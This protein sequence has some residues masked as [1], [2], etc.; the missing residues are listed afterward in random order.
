[1]SSAKNNAASADAVEKVLAESGLNPQATSKK[2]TVPAQADGEKSENTDDVQTEDEPTP[3]KSLKSRLTSVT[4]K[5]KKNKKTFI[6]VSA[7][8]AAATVTFVK[9]AKKQAEEVL[10]EVETVLE[11]ELDHPADESSTTVKKSKKT[12]V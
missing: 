2:A 12:S 4:A 1:M 11:P 8:A 5:L 10:V 9:Y 6:A 7:I 3:A